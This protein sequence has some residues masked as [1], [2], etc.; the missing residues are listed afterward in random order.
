MVC[1]D[2]YNDGIMLLFVCTMGW[3]DLLLCKPPEN[4]QTYKIPPA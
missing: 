3:T 4:P 1:D 2:D